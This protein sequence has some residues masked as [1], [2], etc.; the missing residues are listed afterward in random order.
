[1]LFVLAVGATIV[2]TYLATI[3]L[4]G[5]LSSRSFTSRH[6]QTYNSYEDQ[7]TPV[8][9]KLWD[10][11]LFATV[12]GGTLLVVIGAALFKT[13]QLRS[14]GRA[15][16]EMVGGR[17]VDAQ[18]T[19]LKEKRL[20]N[21]VEEMAIASG[22]PVPSVY[23]LDDEVG[24]NAFAAGL[25]TSDAVVTVTRGT[26]E[27]L[28]RDE[29][30][31]VVAHE[32]SHILNGDMR[33]NIRLVAVLFGIFFLT[34]VG[35]GLLRVLSN[36]RTR[37]DKRD[38]RILMVVVAI[39]V[40][41]IVIGYIGYFFGR[42][43][44]AAVSRQREFLADASAVQF[45]RNPG[46]ITGAL[47]KIGG[48]AL[49]S[50]ISSA[51][52]SAI[53]HFFFAEG[54]TSNFMGMLATHPP[55]ATRIRAIDPQFDGKY[56]EPPETID[57]AH[58]SFVS[59]GLVPPPLRSQSPS[60]PI[61]STAA[62]AIASIGMLTSE[63]VTN[64][65]SLIDEI[66]VRLRQAARLTSEAR[67]LIFG[68]LLDNK[69]EIQQRQIAALPAEVVALLQE[70]A[71]PLA[72]LRPEH[73]LPL[74]QLALPA[75]RDLPVASHADFFAIVQALAAAD[76]HVS[77]FEFALQ[78][79]L[80]RQ[81]LLSH[82]PRLSTGAQI[83]SFQAVREPI[84]VML[85]AMAHASSENPN[86]AR[87]AFAEGTRQL[88]NL[89]GQLELL[90]PESCSPIQLDPA[91]NLLTTAAGPIKQ[92]L[93]LACTEVAGADGQIRVAEAELLRAFAAFLDCP[94]PPLMLAKRPA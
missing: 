54:V 94:M 7:N 38:G 37:G 49:G 63:Q 9:I 93:L 55:L 45:T 30:Q 62:A 74:C 64:A 88:K 47:K 70:L 59:A 19:D 50:R 60:S 6:R 42:L 20:L 51:H 21:I 82:S 61:N 69:A 71:T 81:L 41:L 3:L 24:L 83:Y 26:L 31:G 52:A 39:G 32:F 34:I 78:K 57:V 40:V 80:Q 12:A 48:Y 44:Q 10:P 15:V 5:Q 8:E 89:E 87:K 91:L 77:T 4:V 23:V 73:K 1:V 75:L 17:P 16:A 72:S 79:L 27:K 85:S 36:S 29:L 43:I 33:M 2:V 46:G 11:R 84:C 66:P 14:G 25:T 53:G 58:E 68:L 13:T 18:T 56:L 35:R 22:I 76:G 86:E 65:Q 90:T 67:A 28:N 92:R